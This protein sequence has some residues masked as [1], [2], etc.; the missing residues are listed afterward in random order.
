MRHKDRVL[1]TGHLRNR[2]HA[3]QS[4]RR[5]HGRLQCDS[6]AETPKDGTSTVRH[7]QVLVRRAGMGV[8]VALGNADTTPY[9]AP[10]TLHQRHVWKRRL[11]SRGWPQPGDS[12]TVHQQCKVYLNRALCRKTMTVPGI[13]K[14]TGETPTDITRNGKLTV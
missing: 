5:G 4:S 13:C 2:V 11:A 14:T 7:H 1:K 12:P 8:A 6:A 3:H 10:Y 9:T